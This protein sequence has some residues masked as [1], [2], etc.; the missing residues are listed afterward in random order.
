MSKYNKRYDQKQKLEIIN[1]F[2][3]H[4]G[5]RTKRRYDLS[6]TSIRN[7][8]EILEE[9]GPQ[10][11]ALKRVSKQENAELTRLRRENKALKTLV[12]DKELELRIKD[13]LLKKSQ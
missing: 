5:A 9:H 3:Q 11:L 6:L 1:Y 2:K 12:A 4:G 13:M 7:W 8:I 10:G